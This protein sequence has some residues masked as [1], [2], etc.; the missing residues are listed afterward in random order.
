MVQAFLGK[1]KIIEFVKVNKIYLRGTKGFTMTKEEEIMQFLHERVFDPVLNSN[2]ASTRLKQGVRLTIMRMDQRDALG[3]V[4]YFWSAVTGTEKSIGFAR[5]MREEGF[6]RFEEA[7]D[8]FRVR[9]G[10]LWIG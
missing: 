2:T 1:E 8:E 9:F 3:M 6:D 4:Q 7:I 10:N 5:M